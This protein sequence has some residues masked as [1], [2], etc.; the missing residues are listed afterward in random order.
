MPGFLE[1][2]ARE[3]EPRGDPTA[4]GAS[5]SKKATGRLVADNLND[6]DRLLGHRHRLA[7]FLWLIRDPET[8][9]RY[10]KVMLV[11]GYQLVSKLAYGER[12]TQGPAA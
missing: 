4:D 3:T 6:G 2:R 11:D 1:L 10:A 5:R 9:A 7:P 8:Y 12:V